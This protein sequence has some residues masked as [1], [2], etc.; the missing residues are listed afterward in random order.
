MRI[1]SDYEYGEGETEMTI[2]QLKK[3]A[4]ET[5]IERCKAAGHTGTVDVRD[6]EPKLK[7]NC[8]APNTWMGQAYA[9][10]PDS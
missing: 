8:P 6:A 3:N 9:D 1:T 10:I 7:S 4:H 2:A 5:V